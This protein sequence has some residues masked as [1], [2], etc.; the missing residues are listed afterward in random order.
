MNDNQK[1]EHILKIRYKYLGRYPIFSDL[2]P[3]I[4]IKWKE[5]FIKL[6]L[7]DATNE[8]IIRF[9]ENVVST[10]ISN[11]LKYTE[12]KRKGFKRGL[13][14]L[15]RLKN[16]RWYYGKTRMNFFDFRWQRRNRLAILRGKL[17]EYR[18]VYLSE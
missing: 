15:E 10:S 3:D 17:R 14:L 5:K 7:W 18:R 16:E 6:G 8:E 12:R 9:Y 1:I 11:K 2:Q 4:I 13:L